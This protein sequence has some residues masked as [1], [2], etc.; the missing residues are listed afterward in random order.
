MN[1]LDHTHRLTLD[2]VP[3]FDLRQSIRALAGFAP[4][5]GEQ[6]LDPDAVS[7]RKALTVGADA[8]LVDVGRRPDATA[9]VTVITRAARPLGAGDRAAV[10]RAV[11]NWLG[12]DD[13][14]A[15]FLRTA[16]ADP[17][18]APIAAAATGLHHVRFA[19]LAEGASYFVLTQRTSQRVAAARKRQ[20]AA[21]FG[22]RLSYG[23]RE[24]VAFPGLDR[25][26]ALGPA[27]LGRFAAN[28]QQAAYLYDVI[29]GL[30]DLDED[31]LRTAP[32]AEAE[33]ALHEIRGVGDFT[34]AAILLRV[35][36]R[37][38]RVPARMAQFRRL[39]TDLYGA[40]ATVESVQDRYGDRIGWWAYYARMARGWADRTEQAMA[41]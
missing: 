2:A 19:S 40:G 33:A 25:L 17:A 26:A 24:Y 34:A 4:C 32:Y 7:V 6:H 11:S 23:G 9:G 37:P 15:G 3:P 21:E 8:V 27:D 16:A 39:A 1:P 20:L 28:P 36:G 13:D 5:S 12:L 18:M 30:S 41:G 38:D 22:S 35:L 29:H 14:T 31:W 10:G